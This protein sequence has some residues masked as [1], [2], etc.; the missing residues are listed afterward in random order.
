MLAVS[1]EMNLAHGGKSVM[2][3][4]ED[5]LVDLLYDPTQ[6]RV[7][8]DRAEHRRRSAYLIAKRNLQLPFMEVFDRPTLLTSCARRETST[9]APQSLEL[10]NGDIANELAGLFA[11]RLARESDG[12]PR[13]I[14]KRAYLLAAGRPPDADELHL[15]I[16]FLESN[17]LREFALAMFNLNSFLYVN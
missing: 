10:L 5:A 17:P 12:S 13:S 9:H 4:V 8:A 6:W 3:P 1:G 11:A 2:L 14:V 15:S 16:T 7:P